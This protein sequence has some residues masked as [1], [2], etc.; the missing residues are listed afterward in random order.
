VEGKKLAQLATEAAQT[1]Q[2]VAHRAELV[3]SAESQGGGEQ[4]FAGSE[5]LSSKLYTDANNMRDVLEQ[6]YDSMMAQDRVALVESER[7]AAQAARNHLE[8]M[9]HPAEKPVVPYAI[10]SRREFTEPPPREELRAPGARKLSRPTFAVSKAQTPAAGMP[11]IGVAMAGEATMPTGWA[12]PGDASLHWMWSQM[13]IINT[14]KTI[15]LPIRRC[16]TLEVAEALGKMLGRSFEDFKL[17]VRQGC[18]IRRLLPTDIVPSKVLVKGITSWERQRQKYNHPFAIIGAGHLGLRQALE[19]LKQNVDDFVLFEQLD[20]VGGEV[21]H[22]VA[23]SASR[24]QT[25][26]GTYHLPFGASYPLPSGM[27]TWPLREDILLHF[28]TA[29]SEYGVL[30]HVQ[31]QTH[32]SGLKVEKMSRLQMLEEG[33]GDSDPNA[34]HYKLALKHQEVYT[35]LSCKLQEARAKDAKAAKKGG[36]AKADDKDPAEQPSPEE[37]AEG[38][39]G[40]GTGAGAGPEKSAFLASSVMAFPGSFSVPREE[41]FKGEELFGGPIT[42]GAG[43]EFDCEEARGKSVAICG[44]GSLAVENLRTCLE[45]SAQSCY[46]VCRRKNLTMPRAVSWFINQSSFPPTAAEVLA[47]MT[48]MYRVAN[49]DPL[50]YYAVSADA[51]AIQQTTRFPVSDFVFLAQYYGRAEIVIGEVKRL[52][53]QMVMLE[54]GRK[55]EVNCIVKAIGFTASFEFEAIMH[56]SKMFGFWPDAD[57]RRWIYCES[58][59]VDF[60]NI[61]TTSLSP[62]AMR[63]ATIPLHFLAFPK[64]DFRELV[65]AGS[66]HWNSPDAE[67]NQPA[68]VLSARNSMYVIGL[69]VTFAPALQEVDYEVVKRKRQQQCH[70]TDAFINEAASEWS[71]YCKVLAGTDSGQEPPTYPY[72]VEFMTDLAA[73]SET[74]GKKRMAT[75][76]SAEPAESAEGEPTRTWNPFLKMYC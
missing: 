21:W 20:K 34:Q 33:K 30:P 27:S 51:A 10:P 68:Y 36:G 1:V 9:F 73:K 6:I 62:L 44:M 38:G 22:R 18:H 41:A 67:N 65:D 14:E 64:P 39:A 49:D 72:T 70:P 61:S 7:K 28:Q 15:L 29:A 48:P 13:T 54:D 63:A 26:L 71:S 57:F 19:C 40:A 5:E 12:I 59:G 55:L 31:L 42:Y 43:D 60:M 58:I 3:R 66:M 76:S 75:A 23:N 2:R 35:G 8:V 4:H 52:L 37:G 53:H 11:P 47:A 32:V 25:E 56:S 69:V 17:F 46:I 16:E 24:L 45:K 50:G 74:E